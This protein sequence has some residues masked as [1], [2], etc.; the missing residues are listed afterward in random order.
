MILSPDE[1]D[2]PEQTIVHDLER[3]GEFL[4]KTN[5]FQ[6]I[7]REFFDFVFPSFRSIMMRWIP[8][9]RQSGSFTHKQLRE[10]E[11]IVSEL[12]HIATDQISLSLHDTASVINNI[13]GNSRERHGTGGHSS[14]TYA[15]CRRARLVYT[16]NARNAGQALNRSQT[17]LKPQTGSGKRDKPELHVFLVMIHSSLFGSS[18]HLAQTSV[19]SM[20]DPGFFSWVRAMYFCHRG[21]FPTW[22][23]IYKYSHCGF[24]KFERFSQAAYAPLTPEYPSPQQSSY[25]YFPKPIQPDPP[26]CPEEF[27]HWF[28]AHAWHLTFYRRVAKRFSK[29][30]SCDE[31]FDNDVV[32]N[33]RL[34]KRDSILEERDAS[35]EIFWGLN[36][37]EM[38]STQML[39]LYSFVSLIPSLYF[40]FAWLFQWGHHGDLQNASVP[41]SI[42]AGIFGTFWGCIISSSPSFAVRRSLR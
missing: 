23:G 30:G 4:F 19:K 2:L 38:R 21:F 40:F 32:V 3:V 26:I 5:A 41:L 20:R 28:A 27:N 11:V 22:F 12:Q 18:Y 24:F 6:V 37:V 14:H 1:L 35:R 39:V 25:H 36:V 31:A 9:E 7:E 42:S 15:P 34:P 29:A 16:G 33:Q 10:L 8:K 13:K 17:G